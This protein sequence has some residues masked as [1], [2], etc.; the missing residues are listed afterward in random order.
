MLLAQGPQNPKATTGNNFPG[1]ESLWGRQINAGGAIKS[2]QR[3]K[4]FIDYSTF[5]SERS[6]VWTWGRQTC[7]LPRAPSNLATPL[8]LQQQ[9]QK[10]RFVGAAMLLFHLCFISHCTVQNYEAYHYS[11]SVSRSIF[12]QRCLRST[13]TSGKIVTTITELSK[14]CCH[15]VVT[16]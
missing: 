11:Q 10:S 3:Y 12:C 1:A 9:S 16:Q 13:V 7:F 2:Q 8:L 6:Q 4:Y 5:A 15:V 14:V